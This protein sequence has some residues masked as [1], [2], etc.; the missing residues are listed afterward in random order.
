MRALV[1]AKPAPGLELTEVPRPEIDT[2]DVLIRVRRMAICGTDLHIYEWNDWASGA[3]P[4]PLTIGHEFMG[5]VVEVGDHVELPQLPCRAA[6]LLSQHRG[7]RRP[8]RWSVRRVRERSGVQRLPATG[9]H[10]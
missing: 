7:D 10:R 8:A 1:K 5:E 6:A 9:P 2:H 3:V 4:T